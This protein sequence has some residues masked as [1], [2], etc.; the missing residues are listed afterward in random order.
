MK[1]YI[2]D[3]I[4][5]FV[6]TFCVYMIMAYLFLDRP[7]FNYLWVALGNATGSGIFTPIMLRVVK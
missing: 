6:I 7:L 2:F 3:F 4:L 5:Y 1:E